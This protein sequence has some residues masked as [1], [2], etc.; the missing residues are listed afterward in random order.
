MS[1]LSASCSVAIVLIKVDFPAPFGPNKPNIPV[2]I[3]KSMFFNA[4]TPLG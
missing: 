3:V 2:G 1:P 4:C